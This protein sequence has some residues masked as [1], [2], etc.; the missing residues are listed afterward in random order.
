[1][2]TKTKPNNPQKENIMKKMRKQSILGSAT[3][4][5]LCMILNVSAVFGVP[6]VSNVQVTQQTNETGNVDV[7]YNL[8]DTG[9]GA[10]TVYIAFDSNDDGQFDYHPTNTLIG[11]FGNGVITGSNKHI[12]WNIKRDF[13]SYPTGKVSAA[14]V[15]VQAT[16]WE[17]NGLSIDEIAPGKY[18]SPFLLDFDFTLRDA[19]GN[20]IIANPHAFNLVCKE[21]NDPISASETANFMER[22]KKLFKCFL[23]LDY[24]RSMDSADAI[25]PMEDAAKMF[26]DSLESRNN[27]NAL[28]PDSQVG[29]YEFHAE[30]KVPQKVSDLSN[31]KKYLFNKIDVIWKDYVHQYPAG[32]RCWDAVG[33][34]VNEFPSGISYDEYR[35]VIFLSDGEDESSVTYTPDSIVAYATNRGVQCFC[36]G[37]GDVTGIGLANLNKI[38]ND[39]GGHYYPATNVDQIEVQFKKIINDIRARYTLRW[40]TIKNSGAVAFSPSF[41]L[42]AQGQT[43]ATGEIFQQYNPANY[44]GNRREGKLIFTITRDLQ[45]PSSV[46]VVL[47]SQYSPRH[48]HQLQLNIKT[49]YKVSSEDWNLEL[50]EAGGLCPNDW[51]KEMKTQDNNTVFTVKS[52][53]PDD[54]KSSEFVFGGFGTILVINFQ[55]VTSINQLIN[56]L[57][58][59]TIN[60]DIYE[61]V[62]GMTFVIDNN[63]N[64][65]PIYKLDVASRYPA[66]NLNI[67]ISPEDKNL[68]D[69]DKTPFFLLYDS[70]VDVTLNTSATTNFPYSINYPPN[71]TMM[72]TNTFDHWDVNGINNGATPTL[73]IKITDDVSVTAVYTALFYQL[74]VESDNPESGISV[75]TSIADLN[76]YTNGITPFPRLFNANENMTLFCPP[77]QENKLFMHWLLDG[78]IAT[79]STNLDCTINQDHTAKAVYYS[80]FNLT[81]NSENPDTGVVIQV[82]T[83]DISN[84]LDGVTQF[85]RMY[86]S[87]TTVTLTAPATV[88]SNKFDHWQINNINFGQTPALQIC[89]DKITEATAVYVH[90]DAS[91]DI[92][93]YENSQ[94][95]S[96]NFSFFVGETIIGKTI[97]TTF[98][99]TNTG[100]ATLVLT[101]TL[102]IALT[103]SL[104]GYFSIKE[105]PNPYISPGDAVS[106]NLQFA[107]D[108]NQSG[109]ETCD[110]IIQNSTTNIDTYVIYLSGKYHQKSDAPK[111]LYATDGSYEDKIMLCWNA[112]NGADKYQVFRNSSEITNG[113]TQISGEIS[114]TNFT[115]STITPGQLYYYWVNA[116][117]EDRWG[118]L[119]S[120]DSG[121]AKLSVPVNLVATD[122]DYDD[123]IIIT[124][125]NVIGAT[126]YSVYRNETDSSATA[127]IIS[128]LTTNNYTDTNITSGKLYYYWIKATASADDSE[129]SNSDSGYLKILQPLNV[130]ATDGKFVDKVIITWSNVVGSVGYSVYRSETDDV[131]SSA[132]VASLND[133]KF[134]DSNLVEGILYYY[135]V[136]ATNAVC[137]SELSV[138]DIGYASFLASPKERWKYKDGKKFDRLKGKLLVPTLATNLIAGW[139]IGLAS[140]SSNGVFTN[141]NGPFSLENKKNKN[142]L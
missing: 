68:I 101:G 60:N 28:N 48:I 22:S 36:I 82:S 30:D 124:W 122:G 88:G 79:T 114:E 9:N 75:E 19:N 98:I 70:N 78:E 76:G 85:T 23:V 125:E 134:T 33:M 10:C 4:I 29:L 41:E 45:K 74:N 27:T 71:V 126:G 65:S 3:L 104:Q 67:N 57:K 135:R 107:P 112:S 100:K 86:I 99:V 108:S 132:I 90:Q 42:S 133:N 140:V 51:E 91:P 14:N 103:N 34:A 129:F 50:M 77:F 130:S 18:S 43:D 62:G 92:L 16:E 39:T 115:D 96:N 72:S 97:D 13:P 137:N 53:N 11:A 2:N 120:S 84:K 20:A 111:N 105:Q 6:T 89:V 15:K 117:K 87:N 59:A 110:L 52:P 127:T 63:I 69:K 38:A 37:F 93:L 12:E 54:D 8:L 66:E 25:E 81:V 56:D 49:D 83:Q 46:S 116:A 80:L 113:F 142:K 55:K 139:Q 31:S 131:A 136:G 118:D 26:L 61:D 106:F 35:Y 47:R 5:I 1:M 121:F 102:P 128:S 44:N 64:Y 109:T 24:T 119:S 32:S 7:Y 138:S 40:E 21:D 73:Q 123:K 141:F 94:Y 58:A 95:I 17:L